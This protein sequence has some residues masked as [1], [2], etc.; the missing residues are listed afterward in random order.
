MTRLIFWIAMAFAG[1]LFLCGLI[2]MVSAIGHALTT[3]AQAQE[4]IVCE[5]VGE[6]P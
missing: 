3:P 5:R 2:G 4:L 6:R 1:F